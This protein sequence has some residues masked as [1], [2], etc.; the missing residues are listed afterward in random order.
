MARSS[1]AVRGDVGE[2]VSDFGHRISRSDRFRLR[3]GPPL[4]ILREIA[5]NGDPSRSLNEIYLPVEPVR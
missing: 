1:T 4:E 5:L 3:D 2:R